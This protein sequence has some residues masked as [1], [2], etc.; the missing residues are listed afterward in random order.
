MQHDLVIQGKSASRSIAESLALRVE[1][2]QVETLHPTAFRLIDAKATDEVA[3]FC[4]KVQLD[5]ALVPAHRR[6]AEFRLLAM[7]MDSTLITIECID[8]L[9]DFAGRKDEV[10]A[11]TRAAMRGEID[12]PQ[13]LMRRLGV[14]AGISEQALARVYDERL[15]L[16]PGAE[17]MLDRCRALGIKTLLVS[18]GFTYF[19]ERLRAR[20]GL[21]FTHSNRL[22][23]DNGTLT[24]RLRSAIVDG[25]S[26][27]A[28]LRE[29]IAMLGIDPS[30]VIAIG[31]GAND[32]PM[33][34]EAAVSIA[35]RAKPAVRERASYCFNYVG[36]D[37]LLNLFR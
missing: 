26:K 5:H 29:H 23:I 19:T 30:Q 31:D 6:L 15:K 21:D 10:A 24:G 8:E 14:L 20:L 1:A 37:G 33:M 9:A 4:T 22:E 13:S 18:G 12:Y 11:I 2:S 35:Y 17:A 25:A 3:A 32:L 27:A 36:L 16:S 34:A 7:D 28:A